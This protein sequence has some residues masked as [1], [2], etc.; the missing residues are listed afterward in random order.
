MEEI[1]HATNKQTTQLGENTIIISIIINAFDMIRGI[2][3]DPFR[4][5]TILPQ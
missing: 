2:F 5:F 1:E 3:R 4:G